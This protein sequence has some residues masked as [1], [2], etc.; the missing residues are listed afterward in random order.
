MSKTKWKFRITDTVIESWETVN[1]ES[2]F[3]KNQID[4]YIK[5]RLD[6]IKIKLISKPD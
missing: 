2:E 4:K 5:I 6:L 3:D 1:D